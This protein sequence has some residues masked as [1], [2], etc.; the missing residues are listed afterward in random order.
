MSNDLI[1]V[2]E[3]YFT[4]LDEGL[5]RVKTKIDEFER[6]LCRL[7]HGVAQLHVQ[8]AG[9]STSLDRIESSLDRVEQRLGLATPTVPDPFA[10]Q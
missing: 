5:A 7:E 6:G 10:I 3:V 1:Q 9:F 4:R 8:C 2:L